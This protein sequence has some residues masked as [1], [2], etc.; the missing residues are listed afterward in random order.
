MTKEL[1]GALAEIFSALDDDGK[2]NKHKTA[3]HVKYLV[4]NGV[5]GLFVGGVAAEGF[6]FNDEERLSWLSSTVDASNGKAPVIF[7]ICSIDLNEIRTLIKKA[8]DIGVDMFSF[9]QPTPVS[10][11]EAEVLKYFS[12][13]ASFSDKPMMLYNEPAIGNPLKLGT[14]MKIFDSDS[15]FR[16]YKDSTHN[17]I[18]LH[19]LML[20]E[21]PPVVLAGSDGLIYDIV[22]AGGAGVVSLVIDVF[23][24]LIVDLVNLLRNGNQKK[25][26]EQQMLVLRVRSVLK[27]GGLT[28]GYR[29]ASGL[30]GVPLGNPRSP[31]SVVQEKDKEFI[32]GELNSLSLI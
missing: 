4:E 11:S 28:S 19:S 21:K 32:K 30:M 6:T 27:A 25:G 13:I 15:N 26:L 10:F 7:N 5:N 18:D 1:G 29:F 16:Y 24:K 22:M 31:Y 3:Q 20:A 8:E 9:T 23:P 17:L 12:S 14:V 2:M